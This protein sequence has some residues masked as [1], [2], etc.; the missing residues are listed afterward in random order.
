MLY[1]NTNQPS[2]S[3]PPNPLPQKPP[4]MNLPFFCI[5]YTTIPIL[6]FSKTIMSP[7]KSTFHHATFKPFSLLQLHNYRTTILLRWLLPSL[8]FTFNFLLV[9]IL[10]FARLFP[11]HT[12]LSY[13]P[14]CLQKAEGRNISLIQLIISLSF[15]IVHN[16]SLHI[17]RWLKIL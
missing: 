5:V 10:N 8:N 9:Y 14:L 1:R 7:H 12:T 3:L 13:F 2:F 16:L 6:A 15:S 4:Y 17:T 11:K